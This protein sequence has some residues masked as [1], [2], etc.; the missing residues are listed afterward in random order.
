MTDTD[1]ISKAGNFQHAEPHSVTL[2]HIT[3]L[4]LRYTSSQERMA[5]ISFSTLRSTE[6]RS[7]GS[8]PTCRADL[9]R[10]T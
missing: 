10:V 1:Q 5:L 4:D 7:K 9:H 2:G 3:S 8:V 6:N